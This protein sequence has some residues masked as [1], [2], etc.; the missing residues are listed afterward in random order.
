MTA[1]EVL[2]AG[3]GPTGL[4]LACGLRQHG[5]SV[6]VLDRAASP[7]TT[8]RANIVHARG[9]EV[10]N[11]LGAL[12][13]LR[14]RSVSA[15]K[16]SLHVGGRHAA[17]IEFGEVEGAQ[18]SA[19]IVSQA[20]IEAELRRRLK[21]LGVEVEWNSAVRAGTQDADGVTTTLHTGDTVRAGWL[22]GCDGAHSAVRALAG[23][24]FPGVPLMDQW[25]LADVHADWDRD[26]SGSAGWYHRDGLFFAMPMN[27]TGG[28][29]NLWRF[30]CDV[31]MSDDKLDAAEI[32][33]RMRDLLAERTGVTDVRIT[34]TVWTSAF[35]IHRRLADRYRNGRILLAGDSAHIHSPLGGQG[36]N[37]GLGDAENLAWKLALVLRHRAV[38]ELLDTYQT[39]RRPLAE[40]VLRTT[41]VNT[42]LLLGEGRIGR[43][44][45]DRV[46]TP[47]S[48]LSLVQRWVTYAASQLW[49][50]YRRGPLAQTR[51]GSRPRPGDRVRDVECLRADG[52]PTRLHRELRG[53]WVVIGDA[54]VA[55]EWLGASVVALTVSGET[56]ILLIRPDAHLAWRGKNPAGMTRWIRKAMRAGK[57]R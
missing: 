28:Q 32:T 15:I 16:M 25:L 1:T 57:V 45:R 3:A 33:E 2:V 30:M 31:P 51:W 49:V 55:R 19:L 29:D 34:D 42:K 39:E 43:S 40:Q 26:R 4:A 23:I 48:R 5:I 50:S 20:E 52:T 36:M 8:S 27:E 56:D 12:G 53:H 41:T 6:R 21:D 47:L 10:L 22:A 13:N 14:Q 54:P 11:R 24:R 37:T 46:L 17:T 44:L 7:A 38:E 18:L 35:R 9:V